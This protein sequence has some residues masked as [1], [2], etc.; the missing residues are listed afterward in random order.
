MTHNGYSFPVGA[1]TVSR[2][3]THTNFPGCSHFW[4]A[5][6]KVGSAVPRRN[7][8]DQLIYVTPRA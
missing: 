3:A 5:K 4:R 8:S 1:V 7:R 6:V 2:G